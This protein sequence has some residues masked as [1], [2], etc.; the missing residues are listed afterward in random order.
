MPFRFAPSLISSSIYKDLSD[1]QVH[2]L[3]SYS[4]EL[5]TDFKKNLEPIQ[6]LEFQSH[7]LVVRAMAVTI[8]LN[9]S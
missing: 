1:R 9:T 7:L 3:R 8:L 2:E 5:T 6:I 4:Y